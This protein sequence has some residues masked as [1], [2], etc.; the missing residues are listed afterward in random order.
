MKLIKLFQYQFHK[1]THF[2]RAL[3][4]LKYIQPNFDNLFDKKKIHI[5]DEH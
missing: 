4:S 2:F 1:N 3:I 5:L